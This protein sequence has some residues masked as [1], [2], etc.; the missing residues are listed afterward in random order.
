MSF[1]GN[2]LIVDDDKAILR[3]LEIL[4]DTIFENVQTISNPNLMISEIRNNSYDIVLL[5]MNF[6][7]GMNTGNEGLF[8]LKEIMKT[9]KDIVVI[10]ITAY[11]DIELAVEAMKLGAT[12]FVIKPWNNEKLI[13]T[14]KA[15]MKIRISQ[16]KIN[17]LLKDK[18][19]LSNETTKIR[20]KIIGTSP[21]MREINKIIDKVAKTDVNIL[22][23]GEN[24]TGKELIARE[25]HYRSNR[26][27]N[28]LIT[29][30]MAS[31]NENLIESELFGHKKGAFTDAKQD[32]TGRI[33]IASHGTLFLDE[34]GNVPLQIQSKLLRVLQNKEI[35]P[36]AS[37]EKVKLDI[38]LVAATNKDVNQLIQKGLF[39]E[40]LYYR[41]NTVEIIVPPLRNRGEDI[42]QLAEY[43]LNSLRKKYEKP[44]VYLN[45]EALQKL[46]QYHWPGN[47]RELKHTIEKAVILTDSDMIDAGDILIKLKEK[48]D[49]SWPLKFE[50]IEKRAIER[51]IINNNGKLIDAAKELGLTRQT[52]HNKC[53]KFGINP[54][55]KTQ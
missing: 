36:L 29:V 1:E 37:N 24:G 11:G 23:R 5:D 8:W 14:L 49:G 54:K 25:I 48:N 41:L 2:I 43:F 31:L 39:R 53:K 45:Q 26:I 17:H 27:N 38:R 42:I 9:D 35:I 47:I 44:S 7:A 12:D 30:D 34:I 51:A 55:N 10:M 33:E 3:S 21:G 6:K 32:K 52:L 15:G 46:M 19:S 40:D 18:E 22:I 50:E 4:L 16:K 13:A 20:D 28:P